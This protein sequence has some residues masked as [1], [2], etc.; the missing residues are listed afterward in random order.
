[1]T[2]YDDFTVHFECSA[3]NNP[4]YFEVLSMRGREEVGRLFRYEVVCALLE[5][6]QLT[7]GDMDDIIGG[8][9]RLW[10]GEDAHEINGVVRR[11]ELIEGQDALT[12]T[13]Y[14]FTVVPRLWDLGLTR[15][16]WIYQNK[17]VDDILRKAFTETL[18]EDDRLVEDEDFKFDLT[19]EHP[20]RE[21]TVQYEESHFD[22]ISRQIEHFGVWYFF[23]HGGEKE[24]V[25]FVDHNSKFRALEEFDEVLFQSNF[26]VSGAADIPEVMTQIGI[27][28]QPVHRNVHLRDYNYRIPSVPLVVENPCD[29]DAGIGESHV[30][31]DH[32]FTPDE[33]NVLKAIRAEEYMS[34][35]VRMTARTTI[36]GLRAGHKFALTAERPDEATHIDAH[37]LRKQYAVV[38]VEHEYVRGGLPDDDLPYA[39]RLELMPLEL[40]FRPERLTPWPRIHGITHATVDAEGDDDGISAPVDEFGRYVVVMPWDV[41]GET[42]GSATCRIRV[43]TASSGA[44][45]G[46]STQIHVGMEVGIAH[47]G[48]HPDRPVIIGSLP[49]MENPAVVTSGNAN[50]SILASRTGMR[51][52]MS[53][54]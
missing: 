2:T 12:N 43:A 45:W 11:I 38:A 33:G 20:E 16:S 18:A 14:R 26:D 48:G 41:A 49:N 21:Y 29:A 32:F 39:N 23:E 47:I 6:I 5:G 37:N 17:K 52:T 1:M 42:G 46:T 53:D 36:R 10:F 22:F 13:S 54:K 9:A 35:K 25:V 34:R 4:N 15:G 24:M 3:L 27:R 7:S 51:I 50:T 31:G 40:M 8:T 44:S 28:H 19:G 30:S